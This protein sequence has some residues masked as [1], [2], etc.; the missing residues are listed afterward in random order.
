MRALSVGVVAALSLSGQATGVIVVNHD[1]WTL[2]DTGFA[3]AGAS[4]GNFARNVAAFMTGGGTGNFLAYSTN[5][6]LTQSALANAITADA[7]SWTVSVAPLTLAD[8]KTYDGIWLGGTQVPNLADLVQYVQEGGSVYLMG[9]TG[10]RGPS[11]E[12]DRWNP[13]LEQFGLQF[14]RSS[15]NGVSGNQTSPG[16]HPLLV[17]VDELYF[18]NGN[19]I[20]DLFPADPANQVIW[21]SGGDGFIGVYVPAPAGLA[22]LLIAGVLRRRR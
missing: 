16:A 7:H 8:M 13:F 10:E 15:Y 6:G 3:Q 11:N 5:F 9:G 14:D 2:S 18:N 1:E 12:A 4:A 20:A 22:A 17:G 21:T 19:S